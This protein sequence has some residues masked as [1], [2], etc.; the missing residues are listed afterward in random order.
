MIHLSP[1]DILLIIVYAAS[2]LFIGIRASRKRQESQEDYLLAGRTL[3]IPMFVA[4]L[5]S[6]WYG[7]ILGT[8]EFSYRYG[9]VNWIVMGVPYYLFAFLFALVLAKKVRATN[10]M[11][12]PDKLEASYDRRT[13]LLGGFLT[14]ILVTPAAYVLMLGVLVQLVTGLDLTLCILITTFITVCYLFMGG[15]RSGIWANALEFVMMFVGFAMILPFAYARFGGLSFI[16]N[17]VPP[18]HLI[19]NGGQSWQY[20]AVWFFI[21]L[22][23]LVDPAFHQRCYAARDGKTAQ[24]G[25]LLS[26]VFWFCFDFLTN[27]AGLYARA[28]LPNLPEPL[29]AYPLLAEKILPPVAKGLFY[30]GMLATIMSTLSSYMF[31]SA[32]TVG[33]DIAAKLAGDSTSQDAF[34]QRWTK[35]GLVISSVFSILLAVLV[36][37]VVGIWYFIGTAIIPGLLVPVMASYFEPLRI[38]SRYAF[39]SMLLGWSIS[40]MSLLSGQLIQVNGSPMYWFGLEPMYPGLIAALLVWSAGKISARNSS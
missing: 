21:A 33:K 29:F 35:I 13:A 32:T 11:T 31:V 6:T 39:W 18:S 30:I 3:T 12:I 8:G 7:G 17:H 19:W 37:S 40:T 38:P 36:P 14:F 2:I 34:I 27:V 16:E 1:I 23:T 25:I 26:I 28:A 5:V 9:I 15:F 24:R 20:V 4:T 22:W 10:F